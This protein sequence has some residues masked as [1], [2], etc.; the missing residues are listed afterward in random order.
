MEI[1]SMFLS[2]SLLLHVNPIVE[3][4]LVPL[5]SFPWVTLVKYRCISI[6]NAY[7]HYVEIPMAL[8]QLWEGELIS[9]MVIISPIRLIVGSIKH[10][11][12]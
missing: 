9:G 10:P 11:Y 2:L 5:L 4:V 1:T 7:V 12:I 6:N 8:L 3:V